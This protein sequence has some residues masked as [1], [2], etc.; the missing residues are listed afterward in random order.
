VH[1]LK[2]LAEFRGQ[3]TKLPR[4]LCRT[5]SRAPL[6]VKSAFAA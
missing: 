4:R 6:Q 2:P 5:R 3:D 1:G